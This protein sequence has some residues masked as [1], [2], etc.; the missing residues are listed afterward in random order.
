MQ[1]LINMWPHMRK[2]LQP[3]L[4]QQNLS[5]NDVL[6][7]AAKLLELLSLEKLAEQRVALKVVPLQ[8]EFDFF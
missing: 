6:R 5:N 2:T 3:M 4:V 7:I 8:T 1:P